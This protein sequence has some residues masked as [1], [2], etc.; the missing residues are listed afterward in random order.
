V[1][2]YDFACRACGHRF[3]ARTPAD[4]P[5]PP[6]PAC[7]AEAPER[8]ITGFA[9]NRSPAMKG[10]PAQRS[11]DSRRIREDA[12]AERKSLREQAKQNPPG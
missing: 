11:N 8:V 5:G 7:A 6:C 4:E 9:V 1:P 3:E 12:R 10:A 2:L